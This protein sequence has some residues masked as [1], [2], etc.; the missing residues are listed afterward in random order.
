MKRIFNRLYFAPDE[1][2]KFFRAI[3]IHNAIKGRR[4]QSPEYVQHERDHLNQIRELGYEDK[5][6]G[7]R[8]KVTRK[9]DSYGIKLRPIKSSEAHRKIALAPEQPSLKDISNFRFHG[10]R[11][12]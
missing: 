1:E 5:I 12:D 4:E 9:K 8:I 11:L 7:Y 6:K 10:R 2:E 3:E